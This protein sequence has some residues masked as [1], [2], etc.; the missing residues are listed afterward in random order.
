MYALIVA[1]LLFLLPLSASAQVQ[2][3]LGINFSAPPQL[4][5]VPEVQT[6]E[7]VP[8][9]SANL[10][11]YGGEYWVFVNGAWYYSA[12]YNG[13]WFFAVPE[14]VPQPLLIVPV[15]YYRRPPPEW[16]G[17]ERGAPPRWTQNYGHSWPGRREEVAPPHG[18]P[19]QSQPMRA[20][21]GHEAPPPHAV[22]EQRPQ[23]HA[24]GQKAP[25]PEHGKPPEHG[26]EEGHH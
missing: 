10:F 7:Y 20:P 1:L 9:A 16:R 15:T 6:V 2:I 18:H 17:W 24:T 26:G 11:F 25:P 13:P 5:S 14:Y 21:P 22:Q 8:A 3:D 23:E 4:V 19:P 12:N